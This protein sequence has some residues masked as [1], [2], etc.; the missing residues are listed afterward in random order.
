MSH[1]FI[2]VPSY[3]QDRYDTILNSQF[4]AKDLDGWKSDGSGKEERIDLPEHERIR[5][6]GSYRKIARSRRAH[7][8]QDQDRLT[9]QDCPNAWPS[10]RTDQP[11][12]LETRSPRTSCPSTMARRRAPG[13]EDSLN[14]GLPASAPSGTAAK[15]KAA[16]GGPSH[17]I[18]DSFLGF[19]SPF[20]PFHP[21]HRR[22]PASASRSPSSDALRPWPR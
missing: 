6:S 21:C 16:R 2:M 5:R 19:S 22:H 15:R 1:R 18:R 7:R 10:S 14:S 12:Q 20:P 11:P 8:G 17:S 3:D 9:R 13:T 4:S